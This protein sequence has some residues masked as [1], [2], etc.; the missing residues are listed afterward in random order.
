MPAVAL[1]FGRSPVH[2]IQSI[3]HLIPLLG[4]IL[5]SHQIVNFIYKELASFDKFL[6]MFRDRAD[7]RRREDR[8]RFLDAQIAAGKSQVILTSQFGS[9][10]ARDTYNSFEEYNNDPMELERQRAVRDVSGT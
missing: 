7:T 9:I 6:K 3:L 1:G 5:G 10:E 2:T 4:G 8:D